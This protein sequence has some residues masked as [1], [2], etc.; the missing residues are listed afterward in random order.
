M[1]SS[2]ALHIPNWGTL[3][4]INNRMMKFSK[5]TICWLKQILF[6]IDINKNGVFQLFPVQLSPSMAH[7]PWLCL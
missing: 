5:P 2:D 6:F 4:L 1:N 7:N 3:R